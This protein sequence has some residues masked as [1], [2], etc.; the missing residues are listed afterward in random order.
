M[1]AGLTGGIGSGK[2]VV[3][4]FFRVL[5][6]AV[7]NSDERAK[8]M[9]YLENVKQ[10][11]ISVLG[12]EAYNPDGKINKEFISGKIFSDAVLIE[13]I[14]DIIHPAV[15]DDFNNFRELHSDSK[16]IIKES[17]L[18]FE[19]GINKDLDK[20]ILVTAPSELRIRRIRERDNLNTADITKRINSQWTDEKKIPLSDFIIVN[21]E[22]N[23]VIPQVLEVFKK[24]Q[25][26]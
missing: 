16:I 23:P 5:G 12:M 7:Y 19:T 21:D 17:A 4:G 11:V 9:Y 25:N 2:S 26:A 24:L 3:A 8:E 6:C 1:I 15:A 22:L 18:L 14:N 20:I 13:K 10:K